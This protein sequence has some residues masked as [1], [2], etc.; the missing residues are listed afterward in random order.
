MATSKEEKRKKYEREEREAKEALAKLDNSMKASTKN[1]SFRSLIGGDFLMSGFFRRQ[2]GLLVLVIGCMLVYI[3][4]GYASK[5]QLIEISKLKVRLDDAHNNW[6]TR[7]SE[8][9]EKTRQSQVEKYLHDHEDTSIQ[10]ATTPPF[11][12]K[13]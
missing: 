3:Y 12:I 7:S 5:Q 11:M 10:M 8:L 9:L 13:K 2:L 6:I 1:L 4:N